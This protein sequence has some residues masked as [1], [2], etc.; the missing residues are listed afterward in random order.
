MPLEHLKIRSYMR[1]FCQGY[2][3]VYFYLAFLGCNICQALHIEL[4]QHTEDDT[5]IYPGKSVSEI[6]IC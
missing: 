2:P 4:Y 5:E 1:D 6:Y 3:Y